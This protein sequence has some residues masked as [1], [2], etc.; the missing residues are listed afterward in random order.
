VASAAITALAGGGLYYR[1][2]SRDEVT[3]REGF[4]IVTFAWLAFAI[5]GALPYVISGSLRNPVDA[6]FEAM[7][8]FATVGA[9]T[10]TNV[11]ANPKSVLFWRAL[12]QWF[13]GMGII[14]L[15]VAI[16]PLLGVGGMQ[17]F[18]AEAP[19]PT[20]DRLAPR[21]ENTARLLWGVYVLVTAV[22]VGLLWI[23]EMGFFDALCH[24]L[25]AIATG[26]FSTRNTSLAAFGT[27]SQMVTVLLMVAGGANFSLHYYALRG[28]V[29]S[30]WRSDEFRFYLG[31]I[32]GATLIIFLFNWTRYSNQQLVNLRDSLFTVTSVLTTTGFA[33]ADYERWAVLPQVLLVAIMVSGACTGS[34]AGGLKLV[35]VLLLLKHAILQTSRLLHPR[36][37]RVLKLDHRPVSLEIMHDVLGFT[38][39][40]FGVLLIGVLL[41]AS[42]GVDMV[43]ATTGVVAC[44]TTV[45]PG[46]GEVGP[47][48]N[49]SGLPAF[50]KLVLCAVMLLGRLEIY[51]V[52]VMLFVSFWKK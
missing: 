12:T 47:L 46:L 44:L 6:F 22:G 1:F 40:F 19:G 15:G 13:G 50:A 31:L 32:G 17:L 48:D 49:Y 20:A 24:T 5:F 52:L 25:A 29:Q 42:V 43:T 26:G 27:Y 16:L 37:I 39:L 23:G 9:S 33:T 14:V 38:V 35:R 34:T 2:R 3:L 45:G 41:L 4:A 30:Y 18:E 11:E 28:R 7:A 10:L 21:I 36:Q 51:S 8:G